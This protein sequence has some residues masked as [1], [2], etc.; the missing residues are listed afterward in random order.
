MKI[1]VPAVMGS[2]EWVTLRD[3]DQWES[4]FALSGPVG[5]VWRVPE[6]EFI[7]DQEDL[8]P[9]QYSDFPW[10]LHNEPASAPEL[11]S[12]TLEVT[13]QGTDPVAAPATAEVLPAA[14]P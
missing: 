12:E 6:M 5:S 9:R 14:L 13:R 10:C 11:P 7:E 2:A 1:Y 8:T 4:L 3:S